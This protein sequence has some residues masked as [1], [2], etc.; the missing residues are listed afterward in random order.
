MKFKL[1]DLCEF[2]KGYAFKS[3]D[4]VEDG[5]Y[6]VKVTNLTSDSVEFMNCVK[7]SYDKA[8]EYEKYKL[9]NKDIII[10]T[11]GSWPNNPNSIVGKVVRV[12]NIKKK[13]F[14]NQNAV[15]VRGININQ[16]F[17]Y[18]LL[19]DKKFSDYLIATAQGSASQASIT[20]KDIKDYIVDIPNNNEQKAIAKILSDLDEKIEVNNKINKNLEEMAQAIFKQWF[21]DFEFPNEEGK[22]YKS[23]GGEMVESELGMIPKGW[24]IKNITELV[25]S[26]SIKHK[27]DK[28]KVIFL[29]TS[30]ILEGKFL[31]KE[32]SEISNLPGQAKKSISKDDILYSEIRPKNKRFAYVNF[33][34]EDYVVST[35]LMV[36]RSKN[37]KYS[38][39]IYYLLTGK[40]FVEKINILAE[41]RS[42]TFPQI[43]FSTLKSITLAFPEE[44]RFNLDIFK[45]I[46]D[47]FYDLANENEKLE[48]LRDTLLPKLMSGE[49]R[50]PLENSED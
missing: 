44:S 41:S 7:I 10:T 47:K 12:P 19:R 23:S 28:E 40:E 35:K 37:L 16:E 45:N 8:Q 33:D 3:K 42:G 39:V 21:V 4:F 27:F 50:V 31:N 34:S 36:L 22:P 46:L 48:K 30:D 9:N 14:L 18:Y 32:Y 11:V 26:I 15:R 6:I 29:N 1:E 25:D 2:Q 17:L 49:I 43:T 5:E 20:Q 38:Q 24:K 13:A